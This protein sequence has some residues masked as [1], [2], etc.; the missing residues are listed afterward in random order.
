MQTI[1]L[2]SRVQQDGS[3]TIQLPDDFKGYDVTV[4]VQAK[5]T[6]WFSVL[7]Q[8]TGSIADLECFILPAQDQSV[9]TS[10]NN[11]KKSLNYRQRCLG[12]RV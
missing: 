2:Q 8:T 12:V 1:M 7:E 5:S 3:L 4:P 11:T 6:D 9:V 10:I